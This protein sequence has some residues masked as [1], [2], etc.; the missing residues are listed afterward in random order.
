MQTTIQRGSG[1]HLLAAIL[2]TDLGFVLIPLAGWDAF[3]TNVQILID[4]GGCLLFLSGLFLVCMWA[5]PTAVTKEPGQTSDGKYLGN[6]ELNGY[7]FEAYERDGNSEKEFRLISSP[8]V[9]PAQEAAF[10]RYLVREGLIEK[11]WPETG[12]RIAEETNW[13]FLPD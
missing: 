7:H 4:V 11:L 5:G 10:I 2:I 9:G 8:S 3:K 12:K 13:A 1:S 6:F